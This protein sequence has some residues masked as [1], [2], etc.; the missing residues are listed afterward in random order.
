M[1]ARG[2]GYRHENHAFTCPQRSEH[3]A[4][5]ETIRNLV[6]FGLTCDVITTATPLLSKPGRPALPIIWRIA[7]L[8]WFWEGKVTMKLMT[9]GH[10]QIFGF[11]QNESNIVYV[12]LYVHSFTKT[13]SHKF[14]SLELT[15][16]RVEEDSLF[17]CPSLATFS[18][19]LVK[20]QNRIGLK[21]T[22]C[23]ANLLRALL[24]LVY[25]SKDQRHYITKP[26]S[27]PEI[28]SFPHRANGLSHSLRQ[29]LV[30]LGPAVLVGPL[31]H[32]QP[33]R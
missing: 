22:S 28:F 5:H 7:D 24:S 33:R 11:I 26:F 14:C 29:L 27:V 3:W 1:P 21:R 15:T 31:N 19:P 2:L 13:I 10:L 30:P 18:Y 12:V 8:P 17:F 25:K 9:Q 20:M 32:H 4:K 6:A 16:K 23:S